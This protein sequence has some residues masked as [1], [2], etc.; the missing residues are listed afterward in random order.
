MAGYRR[1]DSNSIVFLVHSSTFVAEIAEGYDK[2]AA[3][4]ALSK[5]GV[6]EKGKDKATTKHRTP[7]HVNGRWF[8][9]F[10]RTTRAEA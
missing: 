9:K 10:V 5:A 6:L 3:A 7:D 4:E 2:T 8:Y 1:R